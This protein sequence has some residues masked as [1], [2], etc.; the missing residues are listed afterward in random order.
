[1]WKKIIVAVII[2]FSLFSKINAQNCGGSTRTIE[3]EFPAGV[4]KPPAVYYQLY[5]LM[6][7][8]VDRY[9]DVKDSWDKRRDDQASFLSKF[10]YDNP[11]PPNYYFWE[12]LKPGGEFIEVP[13]EKALK[14]VL[15]RTD[16]GIDFN[17]GHRYR[18]FE[19]L[20]INDLRQ[21][22]ITQFKGQ[23]CDRTIVFQT[24]EGDGTSFLLGI[25]AEGYEPQFF[26]SNF[27][28]GCFLPD[29]KGVQNTQL[30][31]LRLEKPKSAAAPKK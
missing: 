25:R 16:G 8:R 10:L 30:I 23:T 15:G 12:Q 29:I 9:L 13:K 3:L 7:K 24:T 14:Y 18:D 4:E 20:F 2:A 11:K 28:G 17:K 1:M 6:P 22:H 31:K 26:V 21:T 27:L 19:G 5:Y